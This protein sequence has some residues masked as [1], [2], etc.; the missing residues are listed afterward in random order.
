VSFNVRPENQQTR[1]RHLLDHE[2]GPPCTASGR[3]LDLPVV[4]L[5]AE[6]ADA[7]FGWLGRFFTLDLPM[8]SALTQERLGWRP[9]RPGLLEDLDQD[10]YFG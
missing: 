3:R 2:P 4:A 1:L 6:E 8:S 10:H 9:V 7:H 5:P